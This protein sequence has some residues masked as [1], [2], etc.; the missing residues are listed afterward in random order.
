MVR[1]SPNKSIKR[2]QGA[3]ATRQSS[4]FSTS[5]LNPDLAPRL[6]PQDEF[7]SEPWS[8]TRS[9]LRSPTK[10]LSQQL[11]SLQQEK[12]AIDSRLWEMTVELQEKT[13]QNKLNAELVTKLQAELAKT[14]SFNEN[15]TQKLDSFETNESDLRSALLEA[16]KHAALEKRTAL[17]KLEDRDNYI[18]KLQ[19]QLESSRQEIVALREAT[20]L[21]NNDPTPSGDHS[22]SDDGSISSIGDI[23]EEQSFNSALLPQTSGNHEFLSALG[24]HKRQLRAQRNL[25]NKQRT[26]IQELRRQL[27]KSGDVFSSS[28][29]PLAEGDIS[30]TTL[31]HDLTSDSQSLILESA[32]GDQN[33]GGFPLSDDLM[34]GDLDLHVANHQSLPPLLLS[35]AHALNHKLI[36]MG[37]YER[38]SKV[39]AE[40]KVSKGYEDLKRLAGQLNYSILSNVEFENVNKLLHGAKSPALIHHSHV[41]QDLI[42]N[43]VIDPLTVS[44]VQAAWAASNAAP[45]AMQDYIGE[46]NLVLIPNSVS[47]FAETLEKVGYQV[48][49]SSEP[50]AANSRSPLSSSERRLGSPNSKSLAES[51]VPRSSLDSLTRDELE[52]AAAS[53]GLAI[54]PVRQI[55]ALQ[56]RWKLFKDAEI[57]TAA[58]VAQIAKRAGLIVLPENPTLD[59][60][61]H[62]VKDDMII[63]DREDYEA[64]ETPG[65]ATLRRLAALHDLSVVPR[66]ELDRLRDIQSDREL[67][68]KRNEVGAN[69]SLKEP[70]DFSVEIMR[71]IAEKNDMVVLSASDY[72]QML[73]PRSTHDFNNLPMA[74]RTQYYEQLIDQQKKSPSST[75]PRQSPS[76]PTLGSMED[77]A[78][79]MGRLLIT[80]EEYQQLKQSQKIY[81]PTKADIIQSAKAFGLATMPIDEFASLRSRKWKDASRV[82]SSI[83]STST[84]STHSSPDG[85]DSGEMKV[86][87]AN[88]L[89][90][91]QRIVES[92]TES[93]LRSMANK[94]SFKIV[95]VDEDE[96][97]DVQKVRELGLSRVF[98]EEEIVEEALMLGL[99]RPY[100]DAEIIETSKRLGMDFPL[101]DEQITAKAKLLGLAEP[102]SQEG[103]ISEAKRLGLTTP[104]SDDE[105][106]KIA[107]QLGYL[108]PSDEPSFIE[109]AKS[110]GLERPLSDSAFISKALSVGLV[111]PL[112]DKEIEVKALSLGLMHPLSQEDIVEKA[113][114]L[115]LIDPSDTDLISQKAQEIGLSIPLSKEEIEENARNLGLIDPLTD[116]EICARAVSLGLEAPLKD[117]DIVSRAKNLGLRYPLTDAEIVSKARLLGLMEPLTEDEVM[118]KAQALGMIHPLSEEEILSKAR[119]LGLM[120]PLSDPEVISKARSLGLVDPLTDD[121]ISSRANALGLVNPLSKEQIISEAEKLGLKFPLTEA[122]LLRDAKSLGLIDPLGDDEIRTKARS[123]GLVDPLS[124]D[125][126]ISK[127]RGLG[128]QDP[129]SD[130]EIISRSRSL[131]LVD[132]LNGKE[133][134]SKAK[135]LG[136]AKPL[137][138]QQVIAKA[139][140]LGLQQPLSDAEIVKRAHSLGLIDRPS[141]DEIIARAKVLGLTSPLSEDEITKRAKLLGLVLPLENHEIFAKA[142]APGLV[143][144]LSDE[145]VIDKAKGLGLH[146]PMT[147]QDV[148]SKAKSLGLVNPLTDQQILEKAVLLN[149][150]API[151]QESLKRKAED[152]GLHCVTDDE[153]VA[154]AKSLGLISPPSEGDI[155]AKAR[156]MG[157]ESPITKEE[158]MERASAMGMSN[159]LSN[160]QIVEQASQMGMALRL[161]DQEIIA[162]AESLGLREPDDETEI[163]D[164][165][166]AL[167][168][169]EPTS[170][171]E[172]ASKAAN[173]GFIHESE[174]Q[175]RATQIGWAPILNE[176]EIIIKAK[177]LGLLKPVSEEFYQKAQQL[178]LQSMTLEFIKSSAH[179]L[180]MIERPTAEQIKQ[181]A[182][183]FGLVVSDLADQSKLNGSAENTTRGKM[184]GMSS[185]STISAMG[186]DNEGSDQTETPVLK[187]ERLD[188]A[189][190]MTGGDLDE[191]TSRPENSFDEFDVFQ[192]S[193]QSS[194][195]AAA[196]LF[197]RRLSHS[198]E[199]PHLPGSS[200][201]NS[202]MRSENNG[203]QISHRSSNAQDNRAR[204]SSA[205]FPPPGAN[206]LHS[207]GETPVRKV[208]RYEVRG[209]RS[210]WKSN[211]PLNFSRLSRTPG[212]SR[213]ADRISNSTQSSLRSFTK[214]KFKSR[215]SS[216][217]GRSTKTSIR[218]HTGL[219]HHTVSMK[220]LITPTDME[221]LLSQVMMGEVLHKYYGG[222]NF[223]GITGGRHK[224]FFWFH[225]ESRLLYWNREN[226]IV[227]G[228]GVAK[229]ITLVEVDEFIDRNPLPSGLFHRSLVLKGREREVRV[230]CSTQNRHSVWLAALRHVLSPESNN[231]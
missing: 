144:P 82:K 3:A 11:S 165:A 212:P 204:R 225:P 42:S 27:S 26:E 10:S 38:L 59:E 189:E 78:K 199:P 145:E 81:E 191:I 142:K 123:L 12:D 4:S 136:L 63:V 90:A 223:E 155:I 100:S 210:P 226:P 73:K 228:T 55:E 208:A 154:K 156:S 22:I 97:T 175:E 182:N 109:L 132:P 139:E 201:V 48:V 227:L 18:E 219:S 108:Y 31:E 217:L 102:L 129:L 173:L 49:C 218:T 28:W 176:K 25:L 206:K 33:K 61:N 56:N 214:D 62:I 64:L 103:V 114:K 17:E 121:E 110:L 70:V 29:D 193:T 107:K 58:E 44:N 105:I 161:S 135:Q 99:I 178:G 79:R 138:D 120:N 96:S 162:A 192:T 30:D 125:E 106:L 137:S 51:A 46:N 221:H 148:L 216:N 134:I 194:T 172:V 116:D 159:T 158:I 163:L 151:T 140:A 84:S 160:E 15:D 213:N 104:L 43:S 124:D 200:R 39:E 183:E 128:L 85:D 47:A 196:N 66:N 45:K 53:Q 83:S 41:L 118:M 14:R 181:M 65:P 32:S 93:D 211:P 113:K 50:G 215:S 186:S 190:V 37:E 197:T 19:S 94:L 166:K 150:E 168:L 127:A 203:A 180:G 119:E 16:Q 6:D 20:S 68:Q 9:S 112:S 24:K 177:T 101:N 115:G 141:D 169:V 122:E 77:R 153:L 164:K 2:A 1:K 69:S 143:K 230:T 35:Q 133:I 149:P 130:A 220:S 23:T 167:G 222:I 224:R 87:P 174:M 21:K 170:D 184:P 86:V 75:S 111:K 57:P 92:P 179:Q 8:P 13:S 74:Q 187:E 34:T 40:S 76:N 71:Q 117:E 95:A 80:P 157:L 205:P 146:H 72:Q 126:I 171:L 231:Y 195:S 52:S 188:R 147:N 88:Y 98:S 152:M 7:G 202:V 91:L 54:L 198:V 131:G 5:S 36:P 67:Q 89:A 185:D 60:L 229:S 207:A 209:L